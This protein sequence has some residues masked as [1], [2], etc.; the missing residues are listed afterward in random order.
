[1]HWITTSILVVFLSASGAQA[2]TPT[3]PPKQ[4][5]AQTQTPAPPRPTPPPTAP[6][7]TQPAPRPAQA[8]AAPAAA[9]KPALDATKLGTDFVDLLNTLDD[10]RIS[11]DGK[12]EGIDKVVDNFMS[13]FAPDVLAE[14]P[15]HDEEQIGP[16]VLDGSGQV[17]KWVEKFAR[18]NVSLKY[19]LTRQT[20]KEYEGE[21]M[22][23]S[24][25]L[26]WGGLGVSFQIIAAYSLRQDR[27]R[28]VEPGAVFLQFRPDGK[29]ERL[30]LIQSEKN[31]VIYNFE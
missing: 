20:Q 26:P 12:E 28:F 11:M 8:Q 18:S 5:P 29:I 19:I 23:Y 14:V 16:V 17:R 2:Q 13:H 15:P 30:R 7:Q 25:P 3:Q 4:A 21:V 6:A 9:A 31:E 1:M 27:R 22:V 10:W 24:K